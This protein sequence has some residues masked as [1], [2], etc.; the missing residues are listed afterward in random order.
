MADNS[1]IV[2]PDCGKTFHLEFYPGPA[3]PPEEDPSKTI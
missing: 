3:V 1:T 2:C